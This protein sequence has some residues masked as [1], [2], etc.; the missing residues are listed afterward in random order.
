M[1]PLFKY[2]TSMRNLPKAISGR[3][4]VSIDQVLDSLG[5]GD[6]Q[7]Q[8]EDG[9]QGQSFHVDRLGRSYLVMSAWVFPDLDSRTLWLFE[10]QNET[11]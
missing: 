6:G 3:G 5:L 9:N 11:I 7:H 8:T 1:Y 10:Q 2:H 4:D